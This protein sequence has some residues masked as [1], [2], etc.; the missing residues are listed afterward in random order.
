MLAD[1][2]NPNQKTKNK[3][4]TSNCLEISQTKTKKKVVPSSIWPIDGT[5]KYNTPPVQS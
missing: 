3:K 2:L 4:K 1:H 5:L